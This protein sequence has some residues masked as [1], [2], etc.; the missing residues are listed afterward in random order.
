MST[1]T[2][3][4][5]REGHIEPMHNYHLDEAYD[6]YAMLNAYKLKLINDLRALGNKFQDDPTDYDIACVL[7]SLD[8]AFLS[9]KKRWDDEMS[10]NGEDKTIC[11]YYS[12]LANALPGMED[13]A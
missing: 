6:G 12:E 1:Q 4:E 13:V 9:A 2:E 10:A 3:Y 7:Q 8:E 11:L 5:E